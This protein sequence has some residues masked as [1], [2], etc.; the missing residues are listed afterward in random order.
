[1]C[2]PVPPPHWPI[3][4]TWC[5]SRYVQTAVERVSGTATS[6]RQRWDKQLEMTGIKAVLS[7]LEG[8]RLGS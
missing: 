5:V 1:V 3:H 7:A 8:V 2:L 4:L 6:L